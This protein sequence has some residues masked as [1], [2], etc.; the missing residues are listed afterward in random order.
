ML[1]Y[2]RQTEPSGVRELPQSLI[3]GWTANSNP[4]L[5]EWIPVPPQPSPE[6]VWNNGS[7]I[8]PSEPLAAE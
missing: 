6:A 8:I 7:W 3:D 2:Y 5:Q 4:K 1:K